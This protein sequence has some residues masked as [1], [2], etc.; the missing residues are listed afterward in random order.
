MKLCLNQLEEI[1][2]FAKNVETKY[3]KLMLRFLANNCV[4][5]V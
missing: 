4:D 2:C 1:N 5:N 3:I